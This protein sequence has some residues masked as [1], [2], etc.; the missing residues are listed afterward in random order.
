MPHI[1]S[2]VLMKKG[3]FLNSQKYFLPSQFCSPVIV[4]RDTS[5]SEGLKKANTWLLIFIR[6]AHLPHFYNQLPTSFCKCTPET[7]SSY[8]NLVVKPTNV[9]DN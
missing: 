5:V 1:I 8:I 7:F 4:R 2:R 9:E 3:V 6:S